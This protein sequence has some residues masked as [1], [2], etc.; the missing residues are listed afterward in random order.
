MS[1]TPPPPAAENLDWWQ[2]HALDFLRDHFR[3]ATPTT[4]GEHQLF[5]TSPLDGDGATFIFRFSADRSGKG[6]ENYIVAVGQTEP[7]YYADEG[8]EFEDAFDLHLGTRFMLVLGVAQVHEPDIIT[9]PDDKPYDV[10]KDARHIVNR[11]SP[12]ARLDKI[13]L[14]ALFDVAGQYFAVIRLLLDGQPVYVMGRDAPFGFSNRADLAP[15]V[16][17][18]LHLGRA[19]QLEPDPDATPGDG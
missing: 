2:D 8:Y 10:E 18:R 5:P 13:E 1:T 7:N 4:L 16:V 19:L 6:L 11:V 3:E 12:D 17:L 15:Q 9:G 14:A